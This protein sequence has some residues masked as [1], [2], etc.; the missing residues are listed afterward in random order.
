MSRS[1]QVSA[2]IPVE[3]HQQIT[4]LAEKNNRSISEM[5][6]ILLQQAVKEKTRN[7]RGN[8]EDNTEH[9]S[10]DIR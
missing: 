7:R 8:K 2:T 9:H 10:A 3:L 5:V 1:P 4:D 6:A